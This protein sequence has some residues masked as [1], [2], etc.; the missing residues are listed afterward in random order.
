MDGYR[1]FQAALTQRSLAVAALAAGLLA[2]TDRRLSAEAFI[3]GSA[4]GLAAIFHIGTSFNRLLNRPSRRLLLYMGE[5]LLRVLIAGAVP[6]WLVGKGPASAYL[7]YIVGFVIPLA[8]AAVLVRQHMHPDRYAMT[9][10][11]S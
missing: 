7:A 11:R 9:D 4:V 3:V 6:V 8:V 1:R 5:S 2:L 10:T